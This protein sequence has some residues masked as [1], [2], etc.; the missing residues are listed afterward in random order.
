MC[1]MTQFS[2]P[3]QALPEVW[4][5]AMQPPPQAAQHGV[6]L[7]RQEPL[8]KEIG[9][10]GT[11]N[12][13]SGIIIL[14]C[15]APRVANWACRLYSADPGGNGIASG[16]R[17]DNNPHPDIIFSWCLAPHVANQACRLYSADPG[18]NGIASVGS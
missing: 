12:P 6:C 1:G 15:L 3:P 9:F 2:L 13:H 14:R 8:I 10:V 18:G 11:N 17:W 5:D 16:F 7:I 4:D